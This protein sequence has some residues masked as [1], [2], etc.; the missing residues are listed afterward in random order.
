LKRIV[1]VVIALVFALTACGAKSTPVVP[2]QVVDTST[3]EP[4]NTPLPSATPPPTATETPIP[5]AT[6]IEASP[7]ATTDP[8]DGPL[9]ANPVGAADAG[10]ID[11]GASIYIL[12]TTNVPVTVSLYLSKNNFGQCGSVSYVLPPH[13]SVSVVNQ[14]PYG[15]YYASAYV[16]DPKKPSRASGGPACI[17]GPDRTTFS[18]AANRIKITGP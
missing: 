1:L 18:V 16:N 15:C 11:N 10:K 9:L 4:T 13:G 3:P 8:C 17:T 5:T 12:N 6:I 2:T 7:T 14:L